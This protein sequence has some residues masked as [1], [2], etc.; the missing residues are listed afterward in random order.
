M[1]PLARCFAREKVTELARK[2]LF[3][4][5]FHS[6]DAGRAGTFEFNPWKILGAL[7]VTLLL[8]VLLWGQSQ[9][10]LK[11]TP[12]SKTGSESSQPAPPATGTPVPEDHSIPL[13]Q[14]AGRADELD[15]WVREI[16]GQLTPEADLINWEKEAK[17]Q[18][19]GLRTSVNQVNELLASNP[20]TLEL[21]NEQ[22]FWRIL[23]QKYAGER[24]L[25]TPRAAELEKQILFLSQQQVDWQATW[26]LIHQRA[27]IK[28]VV[29][30]TNQ[31]LDLIRITRAELQKQLYLVL[32]LQTEVSQMDRQISDVLARVREAQD[33]S[34]S[35]LFERDSLPLWKVHELRTVDRAVQTG[36]RRSF[37]RSFLTISEFLHGH[38]FGILSI[39]AT[40]FLAL[41]GVIK[42]RRHLERGAGAEVSETAKRI[43][44]MPYSVALLV[45]LIGT[46][47][48]LGSAPFD[49]VFILYVLYLI[50]VLRLLSPLVA[51]RLRTLLYVLAVFYILETLHMLIRFPP[52][53]RREIQALIVLSALICLSWLARPSRLQEV[54]ASGRNL[55]IVKF[56]IWLGLILLAF[57]L[58][59]NIF[60]FVSLAQILG[61][62]ALLGG[63][64]GV[65]LYCAS[66]ILML[67]LATVLRADWTQSVLEARTEGVDR[68]AWRALV[69][70]SLFLWFDAVTRLLTVHDSVMRAVSDALSY[71]IGFQRVHI[72]LGSILSFLF[73]LIAGYALVNVATFAL[74]K[75]LFAKFPLQRGLPFAISRVT[76]YI[77][78]V[79]VLL[80]A[81][82]NAGIEL[83]KFTLITGA[84]G[85]GVGFGLQNIVNNFVSGL[86]LLFERPIR[87]GDIVE[88]GGLVGRVRRIGARSSTIHTFQDAEV[89]VPNSNLIS[90]EVINWTLSS[91]RR[92]VDI[93][94]GIAYGTDPERVLSLLL[95]VAAAHPG[96]VHNPKPEAFFLGFG[97]SALNFE[98]RFWTYQET[99]FQLKSD[100]AVR[101]VK[102]LRDAN[103]EIPLPQRDLHIRSIEA[104]V[105]A[106]HDNE[107]LLVSTARAAA[108]EGTR[109]TTSE[110]SPKR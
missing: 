19:E 107:S 16:T 14:I 73:I 59:A 45:A 88:I 83:N 58:A 18:S 47:M 4:R 99:W 102:A 30:R 108:A 52:L 66:R 61:M 21:Q 95:E 15:Q 50:P 39:V 7:F 78:L 90:N 27:E 62:T 110:A 97:E 3:L 103:I 11:P 9:S 92:R 56:G 104:P 12:G 109:K 64:A 8:P 49:I 34:R 51:P 86:I 60:G 20:T 100:V 37:D 106:I 38:K 93:P 44:A 76:Y 69:L 41:I 98:L 81:L 74:R 91:L 105:G 55:R 1:S 25:L 40:Y 24:E 36:F 29:D 68:W 54:S 77:L 53:V 89:I 75:F 22:R 28:A 5:A 67:V 13:P 57:S 42:L 17:H 43:F 35:R 31:E 65:A 71:P 70:C 85:V 10:I 2:T 33:R 101:L 46:I 48:Y 6:G 72:T 32:T 96:V 79:L 87:V 82:T 80:I 23:N 63:F 84:L 94:V 26:D